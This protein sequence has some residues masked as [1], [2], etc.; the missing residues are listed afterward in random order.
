MSFYKIQENG[1]DFWTGRAQDVDGAIE[2]C[3]ADDS[4]GSLVDITV[5]VWGSVKLSTEIR[6]KGWKKCWSGRLSL[7]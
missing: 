3:Y 5:L 6:S 7:F 2:K 4:P 1:E